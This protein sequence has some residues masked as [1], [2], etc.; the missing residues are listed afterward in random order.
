MVFIVTFPTLGAGKPSDKSLNFEKDIRPLLKAHCFHCHGEGEKLKGGLDLRLQ[1]LMVKG[2]DEGPAIVPGKPDQSLVYTLVRD[3]EM[4]KGEKKLTTAEADLIRRWI[5][6]GAKT[7]RPEPVELGNGPHFTE[8]E[9]SFWLWQPVKRPEV[10][11][12]RKSDPIRTPVDAFLLATLK[13]KKLSFSPEADKLTLIRRVTFD[14]IGLPPSPEEVDAF[15]A[16]KSSDAYEKLIDRLLASPHYGERWGRH[17]LDI[18]G[19][20]DSDGYTDS[21]PVRNYAYKYRDYVIQSFNDDKPFDQFI[22]EQLA[23]DEMLA[24]PYK[25]LTPDQIA[26]LTATGFLRNAPDGTSS[27]GVDQNVAR[28]AVVADTLK[29]VSTSLLGLTVGCAQCHDH[30]YDPIPQA[31]YY[32]LRAIFEPA[33]DWKNWR[34]PNARLVSLMTEAERAKAA[35]IEKEAAVIDKARLAKQEEFIN[36]ILE[37]ELEKKAEELREPLREAYKTASA[38]RTP[39]QVK[40]LKDHPTV[41]N[42]SPGSL[43]LYK[44]K[45]A[46][47]LKKMSD[48]AATIRA[49]KPVEEFVMALTE[50]PGKVPVTYLF[51]RGD[52]DQPKQALKPGELTILA[53]YRPTDLPEDDPAVPTTGRRLALAKHLTDGTHPLTARVL[54]N[55]VWLNHFGR[56]IV[57]TPGDFG[58]LGER[59]TH[60]ELLDWLASEFVTQGWSMKKLHKLLMT[61][62][63]YRQSSVR[64]PKKERIDL[65]NRYLWRMP[66]RRLQ[67]EEIRDAMLAVSGK[68][69]PKL[70]GKPVPVMEDEVGQVVVGIDTNDSAG[71]PSGKFIPLKGEEFRRSLYVQVRRSKPLGMLESFDAPVMEPNCENRNA[72]TVAPQSL[73]L[74][75]GEF[76]LEQARFLAARVAQEAGKDAAA[77]VQRAWHLAFARPAS[78]A[79]A[80]Q[81][82]EFM[83]AQTEY[84]RAHPP[85]AEPAPKGKPAPPAPDPQ[86]L[87]LANFCQALMSANRFLY[88]D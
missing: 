14:L 38:K 49:K 19:Y 17:W 48:E 57:G 82:V 39:A 10:P 79:E 22:R 9:K 26:K 68:L 53:S 12:L 31:D 65:D 88:V 20:A 46:D 76:T 71:R 58:Y 56:G 23:G 13:E 60:P 34:A 50:V 84:F 44:Q 74:M 24:P 27:G 1:R 80:K 62:T 29:I 40:L 85:A 41:A 72:S 37:T 47:E 25:N 21:D 18:A 78:A 73:M 54:V 6:A 4:P 35:E 70:C 7:A 28:N 3:G 11:R 15:L 43:Y 33:Y 45:L 69:N 86:A 36:G 30:R 81:A 83:A 42:L 16:D 64:D 77:Q 52:H 8:E 51:S 87:A 61:S 75:N 59:P 55:R 66:V 67:A 2:G 32:R 5:A 63:A